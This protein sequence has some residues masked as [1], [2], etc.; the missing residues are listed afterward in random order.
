NPKAGLLETLYYLKENLPK[1]QV[2][3]KFLNKTDKKTIA[4]FDNNDLDFVGRNIRN[5]K[6]EVISFSSLK[7]AD[8]KNKVL[9]FHSFNGQ[10]DFD[11]LYNLDNEIRLILYKQEK[12]LYYK[13]LDQRK[14]LIEE[15][16]K[17]TDRFKICG[18]EYVG[19]RDS[20]ADIST[21]INGIV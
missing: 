11:Y 6:V 8:T 19:T 20:V 4:V 10:K 13:Y 1:Q 14:K 18:V 17:S 2:L 21:T 7:K 16:I 12:N 3:L 5:R 9:V 15:E